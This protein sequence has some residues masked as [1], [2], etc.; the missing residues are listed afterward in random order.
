MSNGTIT[1]RVLSPV[2]VVPDMSSNKLFSINQELAKGEKI[3]SDTHKNLVLTYPNGDVIVFKR[4]QRTKTGW[5]G[6][7]NT[8]SVGD[9]SISN[10]VGTSALTKEPSNISR[11]S[12]EYHRGLSHP[13]MVLTRDTAK[14]MGVN[15][16]GTP[17]FCKACAVSKAKQKKVSKRHAK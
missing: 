4:R 13:N 9:N 6:S 17:T 11:N 7:I 1:T 15:L 10:E 14:H 12:M 2:K 8:E 3:S 16:E 5:I